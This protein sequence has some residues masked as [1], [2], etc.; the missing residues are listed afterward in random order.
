[1]KIYEG[2]ES[3]KNIDIIF[4]R[5]IHFSV[6]NWMDYEEI[7]HYMN[8]TLDFMR[9]EIRKCIANTGS[10]EELIDWLEDL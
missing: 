2:K 4:D 9:D 7:I 5:E 1:M 3:G 10:R 8:E 6:P